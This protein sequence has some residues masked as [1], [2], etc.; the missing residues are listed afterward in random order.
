MACSAFSPLLLSA[1]C[2][3]GIGAHNTNQNVLETCVP[4]R[5]LPC[6]QALS[7][8]MYFS[9]AKRSQVKEENPGIAFGEVGRKLGELWKATPP[10]DRTQYEAQAAEDKVRAFLTPF[11]LRNNSAS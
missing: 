5:C 3:P 10:E 8:F 4:E 6:V 11:P 1:Q 9:N 7:A 2:G